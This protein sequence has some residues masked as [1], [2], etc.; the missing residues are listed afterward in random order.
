MVKRAVSVP[1]WFFAGW[2]LYNLV[3][4][5]TGAPQYAGPVIGLALAAFVG[6]D[7]LHLFWPVAVRTS[8]RAAAPVAPSVGEI[9]QA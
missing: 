6:L 7:P 3:A 4:F 9:A 5:V 8:D 2:T 1:L